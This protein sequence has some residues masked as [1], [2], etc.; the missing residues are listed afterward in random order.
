MTL[1]NGFQYL[2]NNTIQTTPARVYAGNSRQNALPRPRLYAC[3][4]AADKTLFG[5]PPPP[6]HI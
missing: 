3:G 1:K 5:P 6:R 4:T 2:D